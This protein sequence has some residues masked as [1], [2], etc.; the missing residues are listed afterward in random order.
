MNLAGKWRD[1][2]SRYKVA[3]ALV[4]AHMNRQRSVVGQKLLRYRAIAWHCL[5][6]AKF[7]LATLLERRFVPG[8]LLVTMLVALPSVVFAPMAEPAVQ[9]FGDKEHLLSLQQ[10]LV[11][12]GGS[13]IGATAIAFSLVM[14]A[15]QINV[16]RM[17]HGLFRKLSSDVRLLSAFVVTFILATGVA[18]L[19][20]LA[21]PTL[22]ARTLVLAL[23]GV[24]LILMLFLY[25]YKRALDLIS[26]DQQLRMLVTATRADLQRWVV[27]ALRAKPLLQQASPSSGERA[28]NI[29]MHRLMYFEINTRW[30]AG[31]VEALQH[32]VAFARLFSERG[33][34]EIANVALNSIVAINASYVE[35][36]GRTFF[37]RSFLIDN[38]RATDGF[39]NASLE[40]LR[41]NAQLGLSRGDERQVEQTFRT[42]AALVQV[43]L[44]I[45]YARETASKTHAQLAASYLD[46]AVQSTISH[47]MPDVLME[48]IRCMGA[49]ARALILRSEPD[50]IAT[51]SEKISLIAGAGGMRTDHLAVTVIGMEQLAQ[52]T[53]LLIQ[54]TSTHPRSYILRKVRADVFFLAG[55]VVERV[56]DAPL[57]GNHSSALA[58]YFSLT[59]TQ[60]LPAMLANIANA[61]GASEASNSDAQQVVG[62]LA[63]WADGLYEPQKNLLL[64]AISK[65]SQM[66]FE[67]I[68]WTARIVEVL[69]MVSRSPACDIHSAEGL[70]KSAAW[71]VSSLSWIPDDQE[72]VTYVESV[73]LADVLVEIAFK[74]QQREC[75][76]VAQDTFKVLIGWAFKAG[77]HQTGWASLETALCGA[78]VLCAQGVATREKLAALIDGQLEMQEAPKQALRDRAAVSIRETAHSLYKHRDGLSVIDGALGSIDS[79]LLRPVLES[80]ADQLSP[81]E[82]KNPG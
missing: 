43:Y 82:E 18:A 60:N 58:P 36:K 19:S 52:L 29:D 34:H 63:D 31:A 71:L 28:V 33:D 48:G 64:S 2:L 74:A 55:L 79:K 4:L 15:I 80:L 24:I 38:P 41:Q 73:R 39:I 62:N 50:A 61:I 46:N 27:R 20:L 30:T 21:E 44:Q 10:F 11:T 45:D 70:Q 25:A 57:S 42:M 65:R 9:G 12:L 72:T 8:L 7:R 81:R 1:T 17:P 16:E 76:N 66:T 35:S 68:H 40:H 49:V 59:S 53:V 47:N 37:A 3:L 23:W 77:R 13:L 32:A 56:K 75:A 22:I 5:D 14:F 78:A 67:L 26:P 6:V 54:N 51:S 69:L